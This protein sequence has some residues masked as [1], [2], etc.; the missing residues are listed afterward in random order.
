MSITVSLGLLHSSSSFS[1][2]KIN[3]AYCD[4]QLIQRTMFMKEAVTK[5]KVFKQILPANQQ[6]RKSIIHDIWELVKP[7]IVLLGLIVLTAVGAAIVQLQTPL[8]TGELI[9]V[10]SSSVQAAADGLGAL[11]IR[12][13]NAPALKLFGLLTA[14]GIFTFAHISLVSAFGENV[15]K[16]L[17]AK[18]FSAIIRQDISFFDCHRSGELIS[19]LTADVSEFKSTFKQLVTQ[20]LKSITQTVGSTIQLFRI[21]TPLTMTMLATMPILYILLNIY[22]AYLRKLSKLNKELDGYSGGVAGEVITNIRTVRAFA[23][24]D[25]EMEHYQDACAQVARA[26]QHM[27][28]HIG[29]FQGLTNISIGCMVLTVL[30]YGGS[31]VVEDKL[32]SGD[33][34]SYMLS[35][36]TAQHSLVSL[37]VLFGQT[38]KAAASA[39]RVFE[40][41]YLYPHVPLKGGIVLDHVQ[42]D[43]VFR[44]L[45]FSYPTR[46]DQKVLD[47]FSLTVPRGTTVALCGASGS[48]KSTVASLLERFYEPTEGDI[49]LDGH[50]LKTLDPSWLR[51]HIGFINQEPVL[52][53][54]SILENIRYGC[55]DATL[56]EVK[57]AARQ[58][59]A[60]SFIEGFPDGYNTIVGERGAALSGGQKQRIAI[61]RAILKNPKLKVK[62]WFKMPLID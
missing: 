16:R 22:G 6:E 58:A 43:V 23:S 48:G 34:M 27:G 32:T 18:L 47:Q 3:T 35:T 36:Q 39:T 11:T 57:E 40:F 60:E 10:L 1:P 42:G 28:L 9:N 12:D 13:L 25:R 17:R 33:L 44:H 5:D 51:H 55:P 53:A 24:E 15:A 45:E 62:K 54:T 21:S 37:G 29:L 26:N 19:R 56:D 41:I 46:P 31:L 50:D 7:D 30:Y 8:V 52:F 49:L 61:A 2:F 59:N 20:G 38:I 14:Q 4:A